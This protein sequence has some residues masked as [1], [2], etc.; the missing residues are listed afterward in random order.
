MADEINK[1]IDITPEDIYLVSQ[2]IQRRYVKFVILNRQWQQ[3]GEIKGQVVSGNISIDAT[4]SIRRTASLEMIVAYESMEQAANFVMQNYIQ[5]WCGIQKN[6]DSTVS[7]YN[8]GM[9]IIN[10]HSYKFDAKSRTLTVTLSDLMS[11]LNGD[12]GG[13]LHAY[14]AIAKNSERIDT[15]IRNVLL[16]CGYPNSEIEPI[17]VQRG[18]DLFFQNDDKTA[19]EESLRILREVL[20]YTEEQIQEL[21]DTEPESLVPKVSDCNNEDYLIPYDL[22]F[23]VGVTAYEIIEKLV[24]LYPYYRMR[25]SVDGTFIVDRTV[26]EEDESLPLL[27]A[28]T[29]D[30]VV[31]SE[32]KAIDW[33]KIKNHIEVWGKDGLY[34]GEAEDTNILSPFQV[35]SIGVLRA[36]YSGDIYDNIYD[37][38]KHPQ[39]VAGLMKD[40]AK[41]EAE[42]ARLK[43]LK[44]DSDDEKAINDR[45]IAEVTR[46]L[47]K[48][49]SSIR[50]D[51][52]VY[53]N[54]MANDYA[55][56]LLY[57]TC[58][59]NDTL[60]LQTVFMPFLNE[61]DFKIQH[62]TSLD[63]SVNSYVLKGVNHDLKNGTSTLN[64]VRFYDEVKQSELL[65][66][67]YPRVLSYSISG[68]TITIH[69]SAVQYAT[70]YLLNVDYR[71][72]E[73][74]NSTT[75]VY[76]MSDGHAGQ[77]YFYVTATA[78]GYRESNHDDII[79]VTMS[80]GISLVDEN[81]NDIVTEEQEMI[82]TER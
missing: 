13:V 30:K 27:S 54:D 20:G 45:K 19:M 25:F 11:D 70:S 49:K 82:I 7:W 48:T 40:Q 41:Y 38:Y 31:I 77:H 50:A 37:R 34:Y 15:V 21:L 1:I 73:V 44:P 52:Y 55:K 60:T 64:C 78:T 74:S 72:V 2:Q 56:K 67:D 76:T 79:K 81:G 12:R 10:N 69:V 46:L 3:T 59:I 28:E 35:N 62:R 68:M 61:V 58:R 47:N 65:Q 66:L 32:D 16:L 6:I 24:S 42:I 18:T 8:H 57:E 80:P 29:L 17:G 5:L 39:K 4:N 9:F 75:F 43:S 71:V 23:S 63:G 53:G 22:N 26:L 14:T 33:T 51:I 36:V